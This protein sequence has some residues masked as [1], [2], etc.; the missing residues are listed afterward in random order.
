MTEAH[1]ALLIIEVVVGLV[2]TAGAV[3]AAWDAAAEA[4]PGSL[5]RAM[6]TRRAARLSLATP[7]IFILSPLLILYQIGRELCRLVAK[8]WAMAWVKP[9]KPAPAP[10]VSRG[11]Y[12]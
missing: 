1:I 5:E 11:P 2:W 12:R 8:L 9:A 3:T 10:P 6:L 7:L 4:K